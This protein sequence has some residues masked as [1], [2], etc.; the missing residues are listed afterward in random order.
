M[1]LFYILILKPLYFYVL[2]LSV[3]REN[4]RNIINSP[5]DNDPVPL[6]LLSSYNSIIGYNSYLEQIAPQKCFFWSA[7]EYGAV[8][9]SFNSLTQ[10]L[11]TPQILEKLNMVEQIKSIHFLLEETKLSKYL[12]L[13]QEEVH[14]VTLN[15]LGMQKETAKYTYIL[16]SLEN[17]ITKNGIIIK[18]SNTN[19][20]FLNICGNSLITTFDWGKVIIYSIKIIYHNSK[21][22]RIFYSKSNI[23]L[24]EGDQIHFSKILQKIRVVLFMIGISDVKFEIYGIQLGGDYNNEIINNAMK[25]NSFVIANCTS[26]EI[27]PCLEIFPN[28]EQYFH[29]FTSEDLKQQKT[30]VLE[31]FTYMKITEEKLQD[32]FYTSKQL[33]IKS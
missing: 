16:N 22:K 24:R 4:I 12:N 18:V 31:S 26:Y 17:Y 29:N 30:I 6:T 33:Y 32:L 23:N 8:S 27:S 14:S 10:F 2:N 3:Q 19:E 11:S 15:Y 9:E 7:A 1:F 20:E 25:T 28:L 21:D 5:F 13:I